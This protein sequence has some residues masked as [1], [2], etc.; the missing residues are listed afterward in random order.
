M[1]LK[2]KDY[3]IVFVGDSGV[4]KSSFV[5]SFCTDQFNTAY[6]AT[7]A[8]DFQ[9][10]SLNINGMDVMLQLWDTAGHER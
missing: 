8:I 3:K 5:Q 1:L 9:V 10:K 6:S 4:G 2:K 7:I